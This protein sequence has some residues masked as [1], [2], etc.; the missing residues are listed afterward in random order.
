MADR[1]RVEIELSP[2]DAEVLAYIGIVN[3]T[4]A[5]R[6]VG[7]LFAEYLTRML[8]GRELPPYP[9]DEIALAEVGELGGKARK[10]VEDFAQ[11]VAAGLRER[12]ED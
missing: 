5:G 1:M 3:D 7:D 6:L 9:G 2:E 12:M 10:I 11:M 4:T 8:E